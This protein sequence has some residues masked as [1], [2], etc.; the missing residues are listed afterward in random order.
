[1]LNFHISSKYASLFITPKLDGKSFTRKQ[2]V[3][4]NVQ[5][6]F[7]EHGLNPI[8]SITLHIGIYGMF[9]IVN[10]LIRPYTYDF[11]TMLYN[12]FMLQL[13]IHVNME[14]IICLKL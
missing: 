7:S 3:L 1:M 2:V 8:N 13:Q 4:K 5:R 6:S 11:T 14:H 9:V 12:L 10:T